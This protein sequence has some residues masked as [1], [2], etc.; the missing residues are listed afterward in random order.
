MAGRSS[1][2]SIAVG[3]G[4]T[5]EGMIELIEDRDQSGRLETDSRIDCSSAETAVYLL[6]LF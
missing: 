4:V 5:S 2:S 6:T 1:S 3:V